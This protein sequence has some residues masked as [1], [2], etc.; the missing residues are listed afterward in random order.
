MRAW[1][2][3]M[4]LTGCC[5]LMFATPCEAG[6]AERGRAMDLFEKSEQR[7]RAG[8]LEEAQRLLLEAYALDPN[9]VL[10]YNLG[11][12][13]EAL[14]KLEEAAGAF[15]AFLD[16]TPDA[17]DRGAIERRIET[18]EKQIADRKALESRERERAKKPPSLPPK[19]PPAQDTGPGATPWVIA[20]AGAA[21]L[22]GGVVAG[23]LADKAH[24]DAV[25]DPSFRG[26]QDSQDKAETL[27]TI[28]NV[29]FVVGGAAVA[30]GVGWGLIGHPDA[31][32]EQ[33]ATRAWQG[34][35]TTLVFRASF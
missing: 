34:A 2:A 15:R 33:N 5:V 19:P 30:V 12:V 35:P 8:Q 32:P 31:Q 14:G 11:R 28:A 10:Q 22:V 7:Y 29:G 6:E 26:A 9:P 18:L 27:A 25:K 20:A 17:A 21:V 23:V 1:V 3:P 13:Y 4:L 16:G 24:D